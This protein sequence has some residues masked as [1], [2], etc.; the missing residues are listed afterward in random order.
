MGVQAKSYKRG[1][2]KYMQVR[3]AIYRQIMEGKYQ[4]G[5]TIHSEPELV[6]IFGVSKM[7]IRQALTDIGKRGALLPET[8]RRHLCQ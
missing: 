5:S 7:T 3:D 2:A 4:A 1:T 8:G 6:N